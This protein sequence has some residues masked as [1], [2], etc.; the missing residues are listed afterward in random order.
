MMYMHAIEVLSE[1]RKQGIGKA[2]MNE[3]IRIC[4]KNNFV[5]MFLITE[6]SNIPAITLYNVTGGKEKHNDY[7]VF[8]YDI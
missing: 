7:T 6:K 3:L 4:K 1:Y 5:K 2:L 8:D